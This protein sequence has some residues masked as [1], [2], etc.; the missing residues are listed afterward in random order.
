MSLI[1]VHGVATRIGSEVDKQVIANRDRLFRDNLPNSIWANDT[2]EIHNPYWGELSPGFVFDQAC[3]PSV[4]YEQFGATMNLI[5]ETL[6]SHGYEPRKGDSNPLCKLISFS[7]YAFV[8]LLWD[9]MPSRSDGVSRE[10]LKWITNEKETLQ[11]FCSDKELVES[12][13]SHMPKR[14]EDSYGIS[15]IW[16]TISEGVDRLRSI[17]VRG[18]SKPLSKIARKTH[19][20]IIASGIADVMSVFSA[21]LNDVGDAIRGR[22]RESLDAAQQE[23]AG[24]PLVAVGHS[25]GGVLLYDTLAREADLSCDLLITAGSQVGF[26]AELGLV[27]TSISGDGNRFVKPRNIKKWINVIDSCDVLAFAASPVFESVT[28]FGFSTLGGIVSSHVSYFNHPS[29]FLR[30]SDRIQESLT[31]S[32]QH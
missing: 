16:E 9:A 1:F 29:L 11:N 4:D 19:R 31:E 15:E 7:E 17:L 28:D 18:V 8:D 3:I 32:Q 21:Q 23:S 5:E 25:L 6:T 26:F 24:T 2:K 12:L 30:M 13:Y 27:P 10:V 14:T 20:E 22:I